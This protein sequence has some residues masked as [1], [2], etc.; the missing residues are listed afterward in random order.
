MKLCCNILLLSVCAVYSARGSQPYIAVRCN[1][2][3]LLITATG[4]AEYASLAAPIQALGQSPL[5]ASFQ[6]YSLVL[7]NRSAQDIVGVSLDMVLEDATGKITHKIATRTTFA[8]S[9]GHKFSPGRSM[10]LSVLWLTDVPPSDGLLPEIERL[11]QVFEKQK[12]ITLVVDGVLL[13]SGQYIGPNDAHEFEHLDAMFHARRALAEQ[14]VKHFESNSSDEA[15]I[16]LL[17]SAASKRS[18]GTPGGIKDWQTDIQVGM[19]KQ[20]LQTHARGGPGAV[21]RMARS[22]TTQPTMNIYRKDNQEGASR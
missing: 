11:V 1:I 19:A 8:A 6:P 7:T 9:P 12:S 20:L 17:N 22:L 3:E 5:I 10:N 14:L 2:P 15:L 16:S 18:S 4:T 13:A 21:L